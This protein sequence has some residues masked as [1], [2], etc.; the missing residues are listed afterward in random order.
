MRLFSSA[1]S[2]KAAI[3][4]WPKD[5]LTVAAASLDG[6]GDSAAEQIWEGR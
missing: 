6:Y 2:D 5:D 1:L 3:G 4:V